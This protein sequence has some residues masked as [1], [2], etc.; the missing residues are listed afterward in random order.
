MDYEKHYINLIDRA[1][2]RLLE[3]YTEKHHIIP[4]CMAGADTSENLV[5]LTAEEHYVAHQLLVKIYPN[6]IKLVYAATMMSMNTWG[7]RP[8]NKLYGWLRRKHSELQKGKVS[9]LK[10]KTYEEIY[11]NERAAELRSIRSASLKGKPSP[12]K[13]IA[14]T[15]E[16]KKNISIANTGKKHSKETKL[17]MSIA[18]KGCTP[19]NKGIVGYTHKKI[20]CPSC[21]KL[22]GIGA[23]KRWHFENCNA[24]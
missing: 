22:G 24:K 11:G 20:I 19:W 12:K 17:N 8:N 3:G 4:R 5:R 9:L 21:N 23:M 1:K 10:G 18:R 13:G 6:N 16:H 2:L 7:N 14:F 15:E